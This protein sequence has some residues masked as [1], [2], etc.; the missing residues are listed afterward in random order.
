MEKRSSASSVPRIKYIA[1]NAHHSNYNSQAIPAAFYCRILNTR[2]T[3]RHAYAARFYNKQGLGTFHC[4]CNLHVAP[5][6]EPRFKNSLTYTKYS[7]KKK[8]ECKGG[9]AYVV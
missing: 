4:R 7:S 2:T 8:R 5:I 6:S 9:K 3:Q 1:M